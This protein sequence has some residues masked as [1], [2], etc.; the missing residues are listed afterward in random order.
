MQLFLLE[1]KLAEISLSSMII[2]VIVL[3]NFRVIN[4]A[5]GGYVSGHELMHGLD[6]FG[7]GK[8]TCSNLF[9]CYIFIFQ[10]L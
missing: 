9:I 8:R 6:G 5:T 4:Y 2:I 1:N 10:R 7:K 3:D